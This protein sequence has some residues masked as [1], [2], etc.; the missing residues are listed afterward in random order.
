VAGDSST[1]DSDAVSLQHTATPHA[2]WPVCW[3]YN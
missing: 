2:A 3:P 1:A